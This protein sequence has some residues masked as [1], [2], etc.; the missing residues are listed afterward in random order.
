M[1]ITPNASGSTSAR[2]DEKYGV[3]TASGIVYA[4]RST[5]DLALDLYQPAT[6]SAVPVVIWLHGGGWF[7]GDRTLAPD[8]ATYFVSSGIAMASIDYRLSG[9]AI[10]PVNQPPPCSQIT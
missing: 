6:D 2:P 3:K 10:F 9:K 8:L 1:K 4:S 7:T 5:G